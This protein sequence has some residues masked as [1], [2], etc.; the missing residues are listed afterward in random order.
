M[1]AAKS[2]E[3]IYQEVR[4]YDRVLTN[5]AALATALNARVDRPTMGGFAFTPRQIAEKR[6]G[7]TLGSMRLSDL[8]IISR[9]KKDWPDYDF[10]TIYSEI[11]NIRDIRGYTA[12]VGKYLFSKRA[13]RIYESYSLLPTGER[14]MS[15]FDPNVDFF[16]KGQ[17]TAVVGIELFNDLDKHFVP[18]DHDE[19]DMFRE[20]EFGIPAIYGI[21]NDRQVADCV[22]DLIKGREPTDVAIVLDPQGPIADGIKAALYRNG[23]PFKNNL[24]VKDLSQVRDFLQFLDL[25]LSFRTVRVGDVRNLF[26]TYGARN[27]K[28][29]HG[30][31]GQYDRYLLSKVPI[32]EPV[33]EATARLMD[34]MRDITAMTYGEALYAVMPKKMA[35]ARS[36]VEILL[37]DLGLFD[38]KVSR[39]TTSDLAY[40]INNVEDLHHNEQIPDNEKRG[41]LLADCRKA[42]YVDRPVVIL[43]GLD[44]T[45]DTDT[46][47]R[48]YID[49][50]ELNENEM[51]RVQVL[52]QQGDEHGR[53]Y[54]V[55]PVTGGE[56]TQ[57]AQ[58]IK[59]IFTEN[60]DEDI[61]DFRN[62]CGEYKIGSWHIEA[63]ES[64]PD[65]GE[66]TLDT[67]DEEDK[68]F[69]KSAYNAYAECPT[70]FLF[71]HIMKTVDRDYT[72][73]GDCL[74]DFAEFYFTYP[75]KVREKGLQ[76]YIDRI[77]EM[78][79]GLSND[80]MEELDRS[81]F[82]IYLKNLMRY[83]DTIRPGEVPKDRL[84]SQRKYHNTFLREEGLDG[85]SSMTESDR[86]IAEHLYAKYDVVF[87]NR[88]I[89]YKTGKPKD[90]VDILNG[91]DRERTDYKEFQPMVY[92]AVLAGSTGVPEAEFDLFYIGDNL[93][94]STSDGFD[95]RANVRRIVLSASDRRELEFREGSPLY[96]RKRTT[97]KMKE[98]WS[99]LCSAFDG[100]MDEEG[101]EKDP[102]NI[103]T[104]GRIS[105]AKGDYLT[106]IMKTLA[107]PAISGSDDTVYITRDGLQEFKDKV[108][109]DYADAMRYRTLPFSE[110]PV[111]VFDCKRCQY[112]NACMRADSRIEDEKEDGQ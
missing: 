8:Q 75:E 65:M 73:F 55:K 16:F 46:V 38:E 37:K 35:A 54:A 3:E 79:S 88:I 94:G 12:D 44:G 27:G 98:K 67:A 78:Y 40:A 110:V 42:L 92:L 85:V 52:L 107:A 97:K 105:G 82:S 83:I 104:I 60:G 90:A 108:E 74:H 101:W 10:K 28:D 69:S 86:S 48:D 19:I 17:K 22:V 63:L 93:I 58:T 31:R 53:V 66:I 20:G 26:G 4:G 99:E 13:K 95:V 61:R 11:L 81:K 5:D 64:V 29:G 62:I 103:R 56:P 43:I 24:D 109:K 34:T 102:A 9:I 89:D 112:R 25:A 21:G 39:P 96:N 51:M 84:D 50:E 49:R 1:R 23:I 87:G 68:G 6:E 76:Y 14:S 45:W 36:S 33:D 70:E 77:D 57:P 2:I 80:C 7:Y 72:V 111:G 32:E 47:G 100:M 71:R 41:V 18:N 59:N 91:F 106:G 15:A 30:L